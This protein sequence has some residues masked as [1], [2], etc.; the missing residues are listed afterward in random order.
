MGYID[1]FAKPLQVDRPR[2]VLF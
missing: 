1:I 2:A